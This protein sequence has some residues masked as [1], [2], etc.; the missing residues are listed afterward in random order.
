MKKRHYNDGNGEFILEPLSDS[1]VKVTHRDQV[2]YFG[3]TKEWDAARP[4]AQSTTEFMVDVDG[5][6]DVIWGYPIPGGALKELCGLMLT[7]QRRKDS[8]R[9]NPEERK[10][11][12][13]QV[14]KEFLEELPD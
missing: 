14:L 13:R 6:S 12:A 1:L 9:I 2:G 8:E 10:K 11:A 3:I 7:A 4:Y 5:I